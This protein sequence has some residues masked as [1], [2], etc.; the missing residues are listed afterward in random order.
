MIFPLSVIE[1]SFG[2]NND[3]RIDHNSIPYPDYKKTGELLRLIIDLRI[4]H[5]SI[6]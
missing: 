6:A 2:I 3:L 1:G 5:N 4:D